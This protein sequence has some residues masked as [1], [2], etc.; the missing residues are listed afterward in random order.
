MDRHA[1]AHAHNSYLTVAAETGIIGLALF[2][3][4]WVWLLKEQFSIYLGTDKGTF[5]SALTCATIVSIFSL[6]LA[7]FFEHNL[8]TAINTL[9]LFF[10]IGMS[11]VNYQTD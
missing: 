6:L 10:L 5:S 1:Y 3:F 9:A 4:F 7:A 11:R 8:L 2:L